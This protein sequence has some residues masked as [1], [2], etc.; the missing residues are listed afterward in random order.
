MSPKTKP[1]ENTPKMEIRRQGEVACD[2]CVTDGSRYVRM[3]PGS[4]HSSDYIDLCDSCAIR[5]RDA[6]TRKLTAARKFKEKK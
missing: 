1:D 2:W 3:S 5:L 4:L 6:I